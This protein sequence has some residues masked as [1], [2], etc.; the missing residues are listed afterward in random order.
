MLRAN[1]KVSPTGDS[2][3]Y[4][5]FSRA[6]NQLTI[7]PVP[8]TGQTFAP[9]PGNKIPQ[10]LLDPT[11]VSLLKYLAH[12][13]NY[14]LDSNGNIVNYTFNRFVQQDEKRYIAKIDENITDANHLSFRIT[15]IPTIGLKGF[16]QSIPGDVN[17]NAADYSYSRQL[18]LSDNHLFSPTVVNDF[19]ANYT[20]GRFS[21]TYTPEWDVKTGNNLSTMLWPAQPDQRRTCRCSTSNSPAAFL[22]S[23]RRGRAERQRG[24]AL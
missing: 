19:R 12:G 3:I 8:A 5:Q 9:F 23:V 7:L 16:D 2:T 10:S 21:G 14:Y 20:R 6:G 13:S 1:F 11:S 17:G 4:Q 24:R 18:V 22:R 15:Q